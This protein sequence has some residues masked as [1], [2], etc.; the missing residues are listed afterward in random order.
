MLL[1]PEAARVKSYVTLE[2][3]GFV[4]LW[5]HAEGIDPIWEPPEIEEIA[6][7]QW[8]YCGRS[9]HFVNAHI[10]V[11]HQL[12]SKTDRFKLPPN[13]N[14]VT[15]FKP[16]TGQTILGCARY[17]AFVITMF[18]KKLSHLIYALPVSAACGRPRLS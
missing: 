5:Y 18:Q 3:N 1:V 4:F 8:K 16:Q 10:E 17:L 12:Q 15:I 13:G 6:S 2:R 11:C 9:E 14:S 7:G